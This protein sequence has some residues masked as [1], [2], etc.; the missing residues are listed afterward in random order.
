MNKP[1]KQRGGIIAPIDRNCIACNAVFVVT[2]AFTRDYKKYCSVECR[3][4]KRPSAKVEGETRVCSW[5]KQ[6]FTANALSRRR[7]RYCNRKCSVYATRKRANPN[8]IPSPIVN[9]NPQCARCGA[10]FIPHPK[11]AG[12]H[13]Y[14]SEKCSVAIGGEKRKKERML[15]LKGKK[16]LCAYCSKG[17]EPTRRDRKTCSEACSKEL[18]KKRAYEYAIANTIPIADR[19]QKECAWCGEDYIAALVTSKHCS[20]ICR[21]EDSAY[22]REEEEESVDY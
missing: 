21:K 11:A 17:F 2:T 9:H 14:C 12:R 4:K 3:S 6:S 22:S 15:L 8:H 20:M 18:A 7:Q 1:P 10:N 16:K 19:V 13:K 5:C